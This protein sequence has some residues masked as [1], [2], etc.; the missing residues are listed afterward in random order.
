MFVNKTEDIIHIFILYYRP[1]LYY[2][3]EHHL[4]TF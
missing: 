4:A 1:I 2:R 3:Q